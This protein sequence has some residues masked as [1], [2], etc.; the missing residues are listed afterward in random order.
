MDPTREPPPT[1]GAEEDEGRWEDL[2][3]GLLI[4][5]PAFSA[6]S[7]GGV[8]RDAAAQPRGRSARMMR[9][10]QRSPRA[11]PGVSPGSGVA[12]S[13][14][15]YE[16]DHPYERGYAR[17]AS[18]YERGQL[19]DGY[20]YQAHVAAPGS[21]SSGRRE[22][23]P[24]PN[25]YYHHSHSPSPAR[26]VRGEGY[27]DYS[28]N[29]SSAS[30]GG[31]GGG[32][33]GLRMGMG[34]GMGLGGTGGGGGSL[35][36]DIETVRQQFDD[37]GDFGPSS[38][39]YDPFAPPGG[40]GRFSTQSIQQHYLDASDTESVEDI[41]HDRMGAM[42]RKDVQQDGE[43]SYTS[44][45][46]F[47]RNISSNTEDSELVDLFGSYGDIRDMYCACK[48]RGF[49][50]I[51]FYDERAAASAK[52]CLQ[53]K[54]LR[55]RK[56][57]I[58]FSIPK[59]NQVDAAILLVF[60]MDHNMPNTIISSLFQAFGVI[61]GIKSLHSEVMRSEVGSEERTTV[62]MIEYFD[63]RHS[64][65]AMKALNGSEVWNRK[66]KIE[67]GSQGCR[68]HNLA[69]VRQVS[70][71]GGEIPPPSPAPAPAPASLPVPLPGRGYA[72]QQSR[73]HQYQESSGGSSSR[74]KKKTH[75]SLN[76]QHIAE[77]KDK[78]TTV[79][80]RNIPNKYTQKMLL[81]EIDA[82]LKGKYDFFYLP[83]DFKNKCNVGYAFMNLTDPLW[84]LKLHEKFNG[85]RWSHFNSGKICEIT[86]ARIQGKQ[87]LI[88][89][90][91]HSSLMQVD[92]SCQPLLLN[93]KQEVEEIF[94]SQSGYHK[95]KSEA[96]SPPDRNTKG[97]S[98]ESPISSSPENEPVVVM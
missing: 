31:G 81:K 62:R 36:R 92:E 7:Q 32:T 10:P 12:R 88:L 93:E 29:S 39:S 34:L 26:P 76:L 11:S 60:N 24:N 22:L 46:L 58:H 16:R 59:E 45:T 30:A 74:G 41:W 55:R 3:A 95:G 37:Y 27:Y 40:G 21:Y 75:F 73:R 83:I 87:A 56:M 52:E 80:V 65:A 70:G 13:A 1:R 25:I 50:M 48:Y 20:Y 97:K 47:V 51:S 49:V 35:N 28:S 84:I 91:R 68:I 38:H 8:P 71:L 9:P 23:P 63:E 61:K 72:Q 53:G 64:A 17:S 14:S 54:S 6:H 85:R 90:F 79:M 78:K 86:Y 44:R 43:T 2:V 89:H 18:P 77:G 82:E 94:A 33:G 4:D 69:P 66:L 5:D 57:D 19:G 15:P 67:F 96:E 42:A 98:D